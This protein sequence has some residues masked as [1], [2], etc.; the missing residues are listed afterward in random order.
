[1]GWKPVGK[2]FMQEGTLDRRLS[3]LSLNGKI[4][5]SNVLLFSVL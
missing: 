5:I 2:D 1:M 4:Q 3:G